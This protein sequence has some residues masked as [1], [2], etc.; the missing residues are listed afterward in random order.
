MG[1][2]LPTCISQTTCDSCASLSTK[3]EFT[4]YWC[5]AAGHCSDGADRK[6]EEWNTNECHITNS[7]T[8][9]EPRSG[10][11]HKEWSHSNFGAQPLVEDQASTIVSAV[12]SS[13]A[14]LILICIGLAFVYLYGMYNE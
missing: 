11:G 5:E 6:R 4:C 1:K 9:E 8:C 7:T 3:S 14:V 12:I 13:L 10:S 2:A